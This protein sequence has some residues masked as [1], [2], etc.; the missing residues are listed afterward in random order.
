MEQ[1]TFLNTRA[2]GQLPP[3]ALIDTS[4]LAAKKV[5]E[6]GR[7]NALRAKV[8]QLLIKKPLNS[9]EIAEALGEDYA[10]IRPRVTE[11]KDDGLIEKTG[12]RRP[13]RMGNPMNVW[14]AK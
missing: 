5:A 12:E 7:N 14:R 11:L 3:Y 2:I 4:R 10:N 13:S 9:D 1:T 8:L 6:K